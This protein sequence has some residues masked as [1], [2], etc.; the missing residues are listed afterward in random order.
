MKTSLTALLLAACA[1]LLAGCA[2][3]DTG[4]RPGGGE[5]APVVM[6]VEHRGG[7]LPVGAAFAAVPSLTV[8]GDGRA[9]T[10]G[11]QIA[12]YPAPALP[13]LIVHELTEQQV[14]SLEDL[15]EDAGLLSEAPNYGEPPI[16]DAATTVVILQIDGSTYRHEA[17]ALA[18]DPDLPGIDPGLPG[19]SEDAL[20]AREALARFID[21]AMELVGTA[22][23]SGS[24][25]PDAFAVLATPI[26]AGENAPIEE[27]GLEPQVVDWPLEVGL[28]SAAD[29][30]LI[31][32]TDADEL[33]A[34]LADANMLTRF[35]QGGTVY[36]VATRPL[37][38]GEDDCPTY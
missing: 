30:L 22:E 19:V 27:P 16:A 3:A 25:E 23:E 26:P 10:Q 20:Q 21:S 1:L 13:N 9:I 35:E 8:Y 28:D 31:E 18:A 11:P 14:L 29:C 7:F 2:T 12:I 6:Q 5:T 34:V 24:Y 38:P 32:G 36:Q 4:K 15:A 37:L 33:R 17:Y